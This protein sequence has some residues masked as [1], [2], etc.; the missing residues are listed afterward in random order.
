M[1]VSSLG[2]K[3]LLKL[4]KTA[5]LCSRE[6]PAYARPMLQREEGWVKKTI[7]RLNSK[8]YE[9]KNEQAQ[10]TLFEKPRKMLFENSIK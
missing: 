9:I 5:F 10:L 4:S 2:N 1:I 7:P 3:E 8:K 6:I